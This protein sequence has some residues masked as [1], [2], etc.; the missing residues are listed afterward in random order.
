MLVE[1][2]QELHMEIREVEFVLIQMEHQKVGGLKLQKIQI[3]SGL[4]LGLQVFMKSR[5][6]IQKPTYGWSGI[7][8]QQSKGCRI[9]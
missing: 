8:A 5:G 1:T 2:D 4:I 7:N 6:S 3:N 9:S